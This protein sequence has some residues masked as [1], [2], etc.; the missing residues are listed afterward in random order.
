MKGIRWC[1]REGIMKEVTFELGLKGR[2]CFLKRELGEQAE[3]SVPTV[4]R[5]TH[6]ARHQVQGESSGVSW[7]PAPAPTSLSES[8]QVA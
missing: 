7:A 1:Y 5:Q 4:H 2:G 3:E 8:G 6:I